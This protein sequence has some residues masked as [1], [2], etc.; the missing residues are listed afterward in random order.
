MI[1]YGGRGCDGGGGVECQNVRG[2][3]RVL[4]R[5]RGEGGES[6]RRG[7]GRMME[8]EKTLSGAW[9]VSDSRR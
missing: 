5:G 2:C 6:E 1:G 9:W 4:E 7:G 3:V 8:V